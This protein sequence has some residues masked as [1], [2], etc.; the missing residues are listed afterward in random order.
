MNCETV[1]ELLLDFIEGALD[2]RQSEAVRAHLEACPAC[3]LSVKETREMFEALKEA[4]ER[5]PAP[6]TSTRH[7]LSSGMTLDHVVRRAGD[8]LGDFEILGE[9]G[10]GG[11]G[12]V[13]RARQMSLNRIVALKVLPGAILQSPKAIARFQNEARAAAKLH[14]TNIVPVYAQG[15]HEGQF[16]YAMELIDGP[17]LGRILQEELRW[18]APSAPDTPS[19]G[20]IDAAEKRNAINLSASSSIAGFRTGYRRLALMLAGVAEGLAHAHQQ[21]VIH[22]D[23]KPQNLLLGGDGQLHITDFGLA[24]LSDEPSVTLSG[25]MLGTPAYMSPEQVGAHRSQIDHRTDIYSLGVTFYELLTRRRPFDGGTRDQIIARIC[26]SEPR[27]PRK[28]DPHIPVDLETICLRAMEKAPRRRYQHAADMAADLRRYAEDRPILSRR[29]GPIEKAFKW[30]RRH[31]ALTAIIAL[32]LTVTAGGAMWTGQLVRARHRQANDLVQAAFDMLAYED[33]HESAKALEKLAQAQ[34]LGPRE[35]PYRQAMALACLMENPTRSIHELEWATAQR[36]NDPDLMYLMAWALRREDERNPR[37]RDWVR[38][39]DAAGGATTAAGHFFHGQAAVRNEPEEAIAAYR[40]ATLKRENYSQALL[41][42]GRAL[43]HWMYHHRKHENFSEQRRS[44]ETACA[45]QPRKAYPRYLLSIAYR[46]S[47][48]IYDRAGD[49]EDASKHFQSSLEW[50]QKAQEA[51]P[52]SPLGYVC[53]A[54][55]WEARRDY[56]TAIAL[57]HQIAKRCQSAF[58]L[59][60]LCLKYRWRLYFWTGK[61]AEALADL[62]VLAANCPDTV[63]DKVWYTGLFPS[64]VH[65]DLGEMDEAVRLAR[66][67]AESMPTSFRAVTSSVAML[68]VLGRAEESERLLIEY[69]DRIESRSLL[70]ASAPEHWQQDLIGFLSGQKTWADLVAAAGEHGDDRLLW[71]EPFF[72]AAATALGEGRR[73]AALVSFRDCEQTYDYVDYDYLATVFVRKLEG[74]PRWPRWLPAAPA[75]SPA[76]PVPAAAP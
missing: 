36:P 2:E 38:R 1:E 19:S 75:S 70:L 9:I 11:M 72:F 33:Y 5:Q 62:E 69:A 66:S 23:V 7:A 52:E 51:E 68:R 24:R 43:N 73:D 4:K 21:G 10:R 60:D 74:D 65:A 32:S 59:A 3:K 61:D 45:L 35:L 28:L 41:H 13:F 63:V 6:R 15:E 20:D 57:G 40:S 12:L 54:E 44:L 26:T 47:A 31:R 64:L 67:M 53:E 14:H 29:V 48:E 39:A 50:A 17:S 76:I 27:P 56:A 8:V 18:A 16:Y 71:T 49:E 22:R 58:D 46:L 30:V 37:S 34:K 55:Y 25:E 42:L